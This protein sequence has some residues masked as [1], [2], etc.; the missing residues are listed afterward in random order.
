MRFKKLPDMKAVKSIRLVDNLLAAGVTPTAMLDL[1][2]ADARG[3][4]PQRSVV[5]GK[6]EQCIEQVYDAEEHVEKKTV[7]NNQHRMQ[8][9]IEYYRDH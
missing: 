3:R 8:L 2:E 7:S 9:M 6:Y 4:E 1:I 5:R